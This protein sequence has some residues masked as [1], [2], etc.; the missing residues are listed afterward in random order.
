VV[1]PDPVE[2]AVDPL[3]VVEELFEPVVDV[4]P[5]PDEPVVA[6]PLVPEDA[7]EPCVEADPDPVE[8][9]VDPLPVAEELFDAEVDADPEP[10]KPAVVV[11][12]VP[13]EAVEPCVEAD[14]EPVELAVDPL[15]FAVELFDVEVDVEP[16]F[17]ELAFAVVLVPE[18]A[19]GFCVEVDPE[20]EEPAL[21]PFPAVDVEFELLPLDCDPEP[22][23]A[24]T[25]CHQFST[26]EFV[27]P[28]VLL[29]GV[30]EPAGVSE[31]G[32][33]FAEV[34]DALWVLAVPPLT[35]GWTLIAGWISIAGC[36][37]MIAVATA[38]VE[39]RSWPC[40]PDDIGVG[41]VARVWLAVLSWPADFAWWTGCMCT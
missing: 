12:L 18:D 8:L 38:L 26:E 6:V 31:L 36:T 10:D 41:L 16:E 4:D 11:P 39:F 2:L 30:V 15:P 22:F 19:V 5:D 23:I 1:D 32:F 17:A 3:P 9:A 35:L 40:L 34:F 24:R 20:L 33:V 28:P 37:L 7:V 27:V 21:D 14:P 25:A 29:D 13:D